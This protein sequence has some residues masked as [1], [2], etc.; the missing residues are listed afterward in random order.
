MMN[1]RCDVKSCMAVM[2]R[3]CM[4]ITTGLLGIHDHVSAVCDSLARVV[5]EDGSVTEY[6]K[7]FNEMIALTNAFYATT[8]SHSEYITR[9][10]VFQLFAEAAAESFQDL[11]TWKDCVLFMPSQIYTVCTL[12]SIKAFG[13]SDT[14]DALDHLAFLMMNTVRRFSSHGGFPVGIWGLSPTALWLSGKR[15]TALGLLTRPWFMR[16][17]R[18][19]AK[20]PSM[21]HVLGHQTTRASGRV[22]VL[23]ELAVPGV[24]QECIEAILGVL[25]EE[26]NMSIRS[27]HL[28][29]TKWSALGFRNPTFDAAVL[30]RSRSTVVGMKHLVR[31]GT[32]IPSD[33]SCIRPSKRARTTGS[34]MCEDHAVTCAS[35]IAQYGCHAAFR[36]V[37]SYL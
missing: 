11:E 8:C 34:R 2:K 35:S 13:D 32:W 29:R 20:T 33:E 30:W 19:V 6:L 9:A 14:L 10:G 26:C 25:M 37:V 28:L 18:M 36:R 16:E 21:V 23:T 5:V 17:E 3:R 24:P 1:S 31:S 27:V 12:M 4:G 7:E 15:E 22:A